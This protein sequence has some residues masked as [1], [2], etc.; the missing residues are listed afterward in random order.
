[1]EPV[2]ISWWSRWAAMAPSSPTGTSMAEMAGESISS[3]VL[4]PM[5]RREMSPG[6]EIL[7]SWQARW[8]RAPY[9]AFENQPGFKKYARTVDV[10]NNPAHAWVPDSRGLE[11]WIAAGIQ[12]KMNGVPDESARDFQRDRLEELQPAPMFRREFNLRPGLKRAVLHYCGLG[13]A[14]MSVNGSRIGDHTWDPA[15]TDYEKRAMYLSAEVT[16]KLKPGA[17]AIGAVVGDG[18]YGQSIGFSGLNRSWRYGDPCLIAQLE[19]LYED[20][21]R[22]QVVTDGSWQCTL[23]GP[24]VKN[25]VWC[26]EFHDA[27]KEMPGWNTAAFAPDDG[28]KPAVVAPPLSPVLESQ[29]IQNIREVEI[30][31][32]RELTNP[33]PGVWVADLGRILAGY[34]ELSVKDQPPGTMVMLTFGQSLNA[35]GTVSTRPGTSCGSWPVD[36]YVCKGGSEEIWK[37]QFTFHAFRYVRIDGLQGTPDKTILSGRATSTDFPKAGAF[38]CSVPLLNELHQALVRTT[39]GNAR[40][41]FSDT[42]SRERT[43]WMTWPNVLSLFD[44]FDAYYDKGTGL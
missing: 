16:G 37:P 19:L 33:K 26:G 13:L 30:S 10:K 7:R 5:E 24:I 42:P 3:S 11:Q 8:I 6:T 38:E 1:M 21:A 15:F 41:M 23:N 43:G 28:W 34:C 14:E 2:R 20:G 22:E 18:W 44:N 4:V 9:A 39:Q 35:D 25:G 12:D 29:K 36:A 31:P 32:V 17:N 40:H 27:G